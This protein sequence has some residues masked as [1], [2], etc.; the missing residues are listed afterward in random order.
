MIVASHQTSIASDTA[1]NL[2]YLWFGADDLLPY[3]AVSKDHGMTWG[4]PLLVAPPGVAA[5]NYP[6][7]DV[8]GPGQ[9]AI[10]FPGTT[11]RTATA[12]RPW[13][14]YV[15]RS[16]NGLSP[17]PIFHSSTIQAPSDPV[18]RGACLDRCAGMYDF[19]DVVIAPRTKELWA[20]AVDTC[21]SVKCIAAAGPGLSDAQSADDGQGIGIRQLSGA[22][23]NGKGE[24][25]TTTPVLDLPPGTTPPG[26]KPPGSHLAATGLPLG[27]PLLG[28]FVVGLALLLKRARPLR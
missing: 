27:L 11:S 13:N 2:Y 10:S 9:I 6:T 18:H 21:T 7:I 23:L 14:Y 4:Q 19:I 20:A 1:G 26:T 15:M 17:L 3:L 8:Q 12:A 22:G 25:S 16:T 24:V 5:V 28:A